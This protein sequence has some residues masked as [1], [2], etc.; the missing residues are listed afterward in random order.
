MDRGIG[1]VQPGVQTGLKGVIIIVSI[2]EDHQVRVILEERFIE[3]DQMLECPVCGDR[4]IDDFDTLAAS[5]SLE[6]EIQK[7][8]QIEIDGFVVHERPVER[9]GGSAADSIECGASHHDDAVDAVG[10][11][12][13]DGFVFAESVP[14]MNFGSD[15]ISTAPIIGVEPMQTI[16]IIDMSFRPYRA[17][18]DPLG[19]GPNGGPRFDNQKRDEDGSN[20]EDLAWVVTHGVLLTVQSHKDN[21]RRTHALLLSHNGESPGNGALRQMDECQPSCPRRRASSSGVQQKTLKWIP[22]G[23]CPRAL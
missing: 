10:L 2:E 15:R 21:P 3:I 11:S 14:G 1:V 22:A 6:L 19:V 12:L 20:R 13:C 17:L 4:C 18:F 5:G 8:L 23:A 9:I 16:R 7:T